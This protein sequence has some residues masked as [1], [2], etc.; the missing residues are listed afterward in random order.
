M[1]SGNRDMCVGSS[2][3]NKKAMAESGKWKGYLCY[4]AGK[5]A[6]CKASC[7]PHILVGANAGVGEVVG[8]TIAITCSE[9]Q[10]RRVESRRLG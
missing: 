2:W 10:K 8:C 6:A 9:F 4:E 1:W 5:A 3:M 7:P